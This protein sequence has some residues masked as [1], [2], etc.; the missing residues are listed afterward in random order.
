MNEKIKRIWN[1]FTWALVLCVAALAVLLAGVRLIG[2]TPYSVLS[3]SMEPA[4]HVGALVYVKKV[5][6]ENIAVGD[7]I[8]FVL[9]KEL[10]VV[11][12]RVVRVDTEQ[13]CFFTKGD[14]NDA[15]DGAPVLFENL[16]GKPVF[17]IP[18]LGY[19]SNWIVN[20]PGM[21]IGISVGVILM[22]LVL[23]PDLLE[24]AEAADRKAEESKQKQQHT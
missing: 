11:T 3:G 22:L 13:K 1:A 12:H 10:V 8:S 17:T 16:I 2:L 24:K 19:F 5:P 23:L 9:N 15:A 21:Y 18:Y 6:P 4:Y 14:A 20:P 7:P